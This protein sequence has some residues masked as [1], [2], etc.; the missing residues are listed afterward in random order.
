V[1][2]ECNSKQVEG[3]PVWSSEMRVDRGKQTNSPKFNTQRRGGSSESIA[4]TLDE[5][6]QVAGVCYGA[7]RYVATSR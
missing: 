2:L 7:D 1:I 4:A 5:K 6:K 3:W